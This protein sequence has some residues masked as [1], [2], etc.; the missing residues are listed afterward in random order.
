MYNIHIYFVPEKI[1]SSTSKRSLLT[2]RHPTLFSP[3]GRLP[4]KLP[5]SPPSRPPLCPSPEP[6]PSLFSHLP[7]LRQVYILVLP[8]PLSLPPS[9]YFTYAFPS[10]CWL[11]QS[12]FVN[13]SPLQDL[14]QTDRQ[15]DRQ[16]DKQGGREGGRERGRKKVR[17]WSAT[18]PGISVFPCPL[19]SLRFFLHPLVS[20]TPPVSLHPSLPPSLPPARPPSLPPSLLPPFYTSDSTWLDRRHLASRSARP[21]RA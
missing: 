10:P 1:L 9:L 5:P 8:P 12:L 6:V 2:R 4:L 20:Y 15:P 16:T 14:R 21:P 17:M 7:P 19:L 18:R 3:P 13:L 11:T